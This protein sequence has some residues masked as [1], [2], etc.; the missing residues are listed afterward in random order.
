MWWVVVTQT[1]RFVAKG[2]RRDDSYHI[3]QSPWHNHSPAH[4]V[5]IPSE[6]VTE[7]VLLM[8]VTPPRLPAELVQLIGAYM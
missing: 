3:F 7:I 8:A 5:S 6:W 1:H 4:T 2:W